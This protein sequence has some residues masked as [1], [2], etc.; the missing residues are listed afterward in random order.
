MSSYV[1]PTINYILCYQ[2]NLNKC[3]HSLPATQTTLFEKTQTEMI[4]LWLLLT[5]NNQPSTMCLKYFAILRAAQGDMRCTLFRLDYL[6]SS[7]NSAVIISFYQPGAPM[8]K[9]DAPV[10]TIFSLTVS[11]AGMA[12]YLQFIRLSL[13]TQLLL[14]EPLQKL[15]DQRV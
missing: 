14:S 9:P 1:Q 6:V 15:L 8:A 13:A 7:R 12:S 2:S 4:N 10:N 11:S 3:S 5:I